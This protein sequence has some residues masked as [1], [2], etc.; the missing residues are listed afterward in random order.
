MMFISMHMQS[1]MH[2]LARHVWL[3]H[4]IDWL[5]RDRNMLY[6]MWKCFAKG[7][8]EYPGGHN[9]CKL[10]KICRMKITFGQFVL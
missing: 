5:N 6:R 9:S 4:S 8:I 1:N 10:P 7:G 3:R 2:N